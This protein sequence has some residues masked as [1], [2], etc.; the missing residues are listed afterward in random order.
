VLDDSAIPEGLVSK[1]NI[2]T[3]TTAAEEV[4]GLDFPIHK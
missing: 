2:V 3:I 4:K 1:E